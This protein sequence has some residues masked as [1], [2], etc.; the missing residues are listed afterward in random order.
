LVSLLLASTSSDVGA[1]SST[2]GH[3]PLVEATLVLCSR[4]VQ[5]LLQAKAD[6]LPGDAASIHDR[7]FG[8]GEGANQSAAADPHTAVSAIVQAQREAEGWDWRQEAVSEVVE[9]LGWQLVLSDKDEPEIR[10]ASL[11]A[12]LT[13]TSLSSDAQPPPWCGH[14][15]PGDTLFVAACRQGLNAFVESAIAAQVDVNVGVEEGCTPL[16]VAAMSGN[17][18]LAKALVAHG[19]SITVSDTLGRSPLD[20]AQANDQSDTLRFLRAMDLHSSARR[21]DSVAVDLALHEGVDPNSFHPKTGVTPLFAAACHGHKHTVQQLLEKRATADRAQDGGFTPLYAAASRGYMEI[22]N[23]LLEAGAG[24]NTVVGRGTPPIFGAIR[25]RRSIGVVRALLAKKADCWE[26]HR[27]LTA[28][29]LAVERGADQ[30]VVDLLLAAKA[31][32]TAV[33]GDG[34]SVLHKVCARTGPVALRTAKRLMALQ[35]DVNAR[36]THTQQTPL[37]LASQR[38]RCTSM[39]EVLLQHKA[40]VGL[41]DKDGCNPLHLAVVC[42]CADTALVLLESG[43]DVHGLGMRDRMPIFLIHEAVAVG[44][45]LRIIGAI[46]RQHVDPNQEVAGRVPLQLAARHAHVSVVQALVMAKATM[47]WVDIVGASPVDVARAEGRSEVVAI[48]EQLCLFK[49]AAVGDCQLVE[50]ALQRSVDVNEVSIGS[51]LSALGI[52]ALRQHGEVVSRLLSSRASVDGLLPAGFSVLYCACRGGSP[53]VVQAVF[54]A[55]AALDAT[56]LTGESCLGAALRCLVSVQVLDILLESKVDC[57]Q[58]GRGRSLLELAITRSSSSQ[59]VSWLM[60]HKAAV[61]EV[62]DRGC[63]LIHRVCLSYVGMVGDPRALLR[64]S[65]LVE[66]GCDVNA[67]EPSQGATAL[68]ISATCARAEEV[69]TALLELG[70]DAE[71]GDVGGEMPIFKAVRMDCIGSVEV[72]AS[73]HSATQHGGEILGDAARL[74]LELE[75]IECGQAIMEQ[76]EQSMEG[77]SQGLLLGVRSVSATVGAGAAAVRG[78]VPGAGNRGLEMLRMLQGPSHDIQAAMQARGIPLDTFVG[79]WRKVHGMAKG[80]LAAVATLANEESFANHVHRV[81]SAARKLP[82][83]SLPQQIKSPG[84]PVGIGQ[85]KRCSVK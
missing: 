31:T 67:V 17:L 21:G 55:G 54:G 83:L 36:H 45:D 59:V 5:C 12:L 41:L 50:A 76:T 38:S 2:T 74:A 58:D 35:A 53:E 57:S 75:H 16:M 80:K 20:H 42:S 61:D 11:C 33:L 32:L 73:W 71:I 13:F 62:D 28:P 43:A 3:T 82:R 1:V 63:T 8:S 77:R 30:Q 56:C 66:L 6:P 85:L 9:M 14:P 23:A 10:S 34:A 22:V 65:Q 47:N 26:D 48:L 39:V 69:V 49:S 4:S 60:E 27:G 84:T 29:H 81:S 44:L 46:L 19:A 15:Y 40:D 68:C 37:H 25:H 78:M 52:A 72:L 24:A 51:G 18:A 7:V 64:L 79:G 70:A